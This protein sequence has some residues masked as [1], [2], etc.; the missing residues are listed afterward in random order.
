MLF[1]CP[2]PSC[3]LFS[4]LIALGWTLAGQGQ[5]ASG[6]DTWCCF[7]G[8]NGAGVSRA[9]NVP[10]NWT[11]QDFNWTVDLPGVGSSS[12]VVWQDRIYLARRC[13]DG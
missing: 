10:T 9:K 5:P 12:P 4:L 3:S 6:Q 7:R 8:P 1:K 13:R 11:D 2:V